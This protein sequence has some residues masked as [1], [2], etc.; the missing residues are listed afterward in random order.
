M[1]IVVLGAGIVGVQIASKLI[2]EGKNIVVIEKNMERAQY[3][4]SHL[5]CMV[6]NEEGNNIHTLKK[7]GIEKAD[8]FISVTNSDE[9]NMIACA[10]VDSEFTVPIKIARVRNLDYSRLK[11]TEKNFLGIDY[12]VNSEVETARQIANIVALGASSD[13]MLFE[14]TELQMRN[15]MITRN[16]YFRNRTLREIRH[17]IKESFL[18][19]GILR[20]SEFIIPTGDTMVKENDNVYL[21]ATQ[22]EFTRLFIQTGRKQENIDRIVIIGGGK[23]GSLVCQYLIRTGRKITII[24]NSY[25]NCKI[26]S[27][28]FPEALVLN[29]DIS[30]EDIFDEEQLNKYDLIIATTDNQE[31]NILTSI[32]AKTLGTRRSI[33]LVN[34]SNYLPIASKL[35]IDATISPKMST[36]DAIMKFIRRGEIKSIHSIF[37]GKAEV[38]EFSVDGNN[39]L[40][41]KKI[42]DMELPANSL[43]LSIVRDNMNV[44][45]DGNLVIEPGDVA[46]II[47]SKTSINKIEEYLAG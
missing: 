9:V 34:K 15:I 14:N 39:Q 8:I 44:L 11:I 2:A 10:L 37:D 19:A 40:A 4:N 42:K 23:I 21:L 31:L 20:D 43:I 28:K 46:I 29:A 12:I 36:V 41:R 6:I 27:E 1:H 25:D 33:A 18:M 38:I 7:A 24:D 17:N 47:A 13:V 45:P 32:Y 26:L 22:K 16:S 5:D 35:D 30:D 3:V